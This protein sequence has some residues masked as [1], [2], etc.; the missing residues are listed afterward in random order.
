MYVNHGHA[1]NY[2]FRTVKLLSEP[3]FYPL[4]VTRHW[5]R[6]SLRKMSTTMSMAVWSVTVNGLRSMIPRSFNGG[7]LLGGCGGVY[8]VKKIR[9]ALTTPSCR[10]RA[11]SARGKWRIINLLMTWETYNSHKPYN[12]TVIERDSSLKKALISVQTCMTFYCVTAEE[13]WRMF[14]HFCP[15]NEL[16]KTTMDSI[17]YNC[18]NKKLF[19]VLRP[20]HTT[21]TDTDRR[22]R[23]LLLVLLDQCVTP[24]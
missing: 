15:Y 14:Q 13:E 21:P 23:T 3:S 2:E 12:N 20:I 5:R 8:S 17:E 11:F 10:W 19:G 7:G 4:W 22:Q 16:C 1:R 9:E 18:I 6:P 24:S